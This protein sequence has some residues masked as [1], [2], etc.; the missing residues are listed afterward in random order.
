VEAWRTA[1]PTSEAR[2]AGAA[3]RVVPGTCVDVRLRDDA[4]GE[5]RTEHTTVQTEYP[6]RGAVRA[7]PAAATLLELCDGTRDV[8]ALLAALRERALVDADVGVVEV[9]RLVELLVVAGALAVPACP[10]PAAPL[11]PQRASGVTTAISSV[12]TQST[13]Q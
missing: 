3:P 1:A 9:A 6:A 2:L 12:P 5:W 11:R 7:P 13:R 8:E 10:V 4:Q